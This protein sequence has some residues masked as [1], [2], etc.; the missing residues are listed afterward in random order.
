MGC[1]KK[2]YMRK[3]GAGSE[4]RKVLFIRKRHILRI[5]SDLFAPFFG[6]FYFLASFFI[7][8]FFMHNLF[9]KQN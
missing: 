6:F 3:V 4:K 7:L 2:E 5:V 1:I 8:Y 9:L